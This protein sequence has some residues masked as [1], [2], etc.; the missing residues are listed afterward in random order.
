MGERWQNL[1]GAGVF[2]DDIVDLT[3]GASIDGMEN[4]VPFSPAGVL[5]KRG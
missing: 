2:V 3:V 5:E 1:P 4:A